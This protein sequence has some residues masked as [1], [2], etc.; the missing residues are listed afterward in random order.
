M[1]LIHHTLLLGSGLLLCLTAGA[2]TGFEELIRQDPTRAAGVHHSYE[3]IPA[4]ET[5][6]PWGYKA[7]YVSHYGRHGSRRA[8]GA[9]AER[10]FEA[11]SA[12]REAGLLTPQG[13]ELY[14]MVNALHE[15]HIGMAGELTARGAREHR[16][17]AQRLYERHPRVWRDHARRQVH[18]QS[19]NIP[20]CLISMANFT[21]SL[22]DCAPQL[23][24]DFVTGE[25]YI[26]LLAHD[27]YDKSAVSE[28]SRK[29][30]DS[31]ERVYTEPSRLMKAVFIDDA[32]RVQ[33][34]IPDPYDFVYQIYLFAG[35]Q[36]DTETPDADIFGSFFTPDELIGWYRCYNARIYNAMANSAEFGDNHLWAARGLVQDIID[37]ADA[38]LADGSPT[39]AVE[40][41]DMEQMYSGHPA[42]GGPDGSRRPRR[43]RTQ[44]RRLR[45]L[46]E[47]PA[48]LHGLQP[49]D[50]LLP[51]ARRGAPRQALLQRAGDAGA[52]PGARPGPLLPLVRAQ[53][54]PGAPD[55]AVQF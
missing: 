27:Y 28:G 3:Y 16:G 38:A 9:S 25:K 47:F 29:L 22:D 15:D 21:A 35:M 32:A 33:A 6:A 37:R 54:A 30:M 31:L 46:A 20:R 34:V 11:M 2:Q 24:F 5:P 19:S 4:A 55:C 18:V 12:A 45:Q 23:L 52:R 51:Q 42:A 36:Q 48:R 13:E 10:A 1:K 8:I 7:F 26:N 53:G 17:I 43:P 40:L 39:A 41:P 14:R 49:A 44:C 50:G